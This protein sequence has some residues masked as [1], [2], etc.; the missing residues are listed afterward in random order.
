MALSVGEVVRRY[1]VAFRARADATLSTAQRRV[2]TALAR[3]R[4]AALGGHVEQCDHCGHR[5]VFYNSCRNRHCPQCQ[6]LARATWIQARTEELLDC[7]YFHVVFTLPQPI[8]EI[9]LQ[10]KAV[11]YG[12]LFR[13]VAETLQTIAADARHL[14]AHIGFFAVLHTWGQTLGHHPHLH[15]VIPGGGLAPDGTRWVACRPGFFL[16]VRVL[17]RLFRRLFLEALQAAHA[18]GQ[19]RFAGTL[20]ALATPR[21]WAAQLHPTRTQDWVVYA[22]PPFGGPAQVLDYV[23]RYT[24]RVAIANQRLLD[25]QRGQVRFRYTDYRRPQ[26]PRTMTLA[27]DEFLRRLLLHVL[28]ANFHRIRD[29]G[30]FGNR[31]RT[32]KLQRCRQLLGMAA[33]PPDEPTPPADYRD[34][35]AAL[36]GVSL[37][38]CPVCREGQMLVIDSGIAAPA[39]FDS[40]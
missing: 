18:A 36:T 14:G 2:L 31:H 23:G 30:L 6:A 19:L 29:Y 22:K 38:A 21:G 16:P 34:H 1:G 17:S 4:T 33:P 15:C 37:R 20:E 10:N 32:A 11:V 27:A 24:H 7:D 28:P 8:A 39:A 9:A 26:L 25:I 12:L 3:C 35:Y 5:R 40:S 13:T